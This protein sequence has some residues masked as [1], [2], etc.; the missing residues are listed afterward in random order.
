ME[1]HT[2][3]LF[4]A[5]ILIDAYKQGKRLKGYATAVNAVE[6]PAVV[7]MKGINI[8]YPRPRDYKL[9]AKAMAELLKMGRPYPQQI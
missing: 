3:C 1:A 5:N 2:G 6:F 4:D 9:A 7:Q 8:I